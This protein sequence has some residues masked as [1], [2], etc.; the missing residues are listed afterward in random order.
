MTKTTEAKWRGLIAEQERSGLTAR[1]YAASR[2][3]APA[4]LYWWRS[5][6]GR[7]RMPA[8][9]PVE[10]VDYGG[11]GVRHG[12]DGSFEVHFESGVALMVRTG[13]DEEELRRLVRV[14]RC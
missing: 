10:V 8:L 4:T 1:D 3:I 14:L 9:V 11:A 7:S 5:R 12:G 13:F 6:L 2:G